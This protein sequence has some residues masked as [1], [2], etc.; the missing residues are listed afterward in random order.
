[1]I[2]QAQ[3]S[4]IALLTELCARPG[5][6]DKSQDKSKTQAYFTRA[7]SE[8]DIFMI[9]EKETDDIA[10]ALPETF[11][12]ALAGYAMINWHPAYPL[13]RRLNIAEIQDLYIHPDFRRRGLA[14]YLIAHCEQ[15]AKDAGHSQIGISV[16]LHSGYGPAQRLY[17]GMGYMPDGNGIAYDNQGVTPHSKPYPI[18]DY[19]CLMMVKEL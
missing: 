19:L 15:N 14:R 18:D 5:A 13:Y 8:R 11:P 2:K 1:M 9:F 4:D 10:R 6:P 16:G 17:A 12:K 7:L 3:D